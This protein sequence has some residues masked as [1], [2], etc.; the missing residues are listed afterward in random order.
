[1]KHKL[2]CHTNINFNSNTKWYANIELSKAYEINEKQK[3]KTYKECMP[4]IEHGCFTPLVMSMTRGMSPEFQ[5]LYSRPAKMICKKRKTNYNVKIT[6]IRRKI[7]FSFIKSIEICIR[8]SCLAFQNDNLE[9][10]LSED[11]WVSFEHVNQWDNI[12][13]AKLIK[14]SI[15]CNGKRWC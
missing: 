2:K 13:C 9:M 11:L 10:S 8:G 12:W 1:M 7:A 4:Q 15:F 3:K 5:K 6:S 14:N